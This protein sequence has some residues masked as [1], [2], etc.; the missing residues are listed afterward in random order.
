MARRAGN[1]WLSVNARLSIEFTAWAI[2]PL[3]SVTAL[4]ARS[5]FAGI[6]AARWKGNARD[7]VFVFH[8]HIDVNV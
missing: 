8:R 6:S 5:A 1:S 4:T 3:T 2:A 7:L